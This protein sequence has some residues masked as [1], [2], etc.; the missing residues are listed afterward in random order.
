MRPFEWGAVLGWVTL[1]DCESVRFVETTE[2]GAALEQVLAF[3]F[4]CHF[5]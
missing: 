1:S 4:D 2:G 5:P 3:P